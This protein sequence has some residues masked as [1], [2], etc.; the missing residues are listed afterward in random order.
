MPR[1]N[2]VCRIDRGMLSRLKTTIHENLPEES[3][4]SLDTLSEAKMA[5]LGVQLASI[6]ISE[7][8]DLAQAFFQKYGVLI[9]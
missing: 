5:R 3:G 4:Q 1:E 8:P 7:H 9:A 2:V 6:W